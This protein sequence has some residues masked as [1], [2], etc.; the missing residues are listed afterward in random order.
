M[1][2]AMVV[3]RYMD[4][5]CIVEEGESGCNYMEMRIKGVGRR[6]RIKSFFWEEGE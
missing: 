1:P 4:S 6:A 2:K 5:M 3:A